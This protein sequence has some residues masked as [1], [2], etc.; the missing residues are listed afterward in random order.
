[1][2][3]LP[4]WCWDNIDSKQAYLQVTHTACTIFHTDDGVNR[5][6][7]AHWLLLQDVKWIGISRSTISLILM[8]MFA[9]SRRT[10]WTWRRL[11]ETCVTRG[12]EAAVPV[13]R[14]ADADNRCVLNLPTSK[15]SA[16]SSLV[17]DED[18]P[19]VNSEVSAEGPWIRRSDLFD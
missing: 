7:P 2:C 9:V 19:F 18:T 17:D 10:S 11:C 1:M 16:T 5:N 3:A 15:S 6:T 14:I 12:V 13:V 4:L 8:K